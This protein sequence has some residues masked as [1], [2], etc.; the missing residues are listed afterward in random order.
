MKK[1]KIYIL[2]LI[3]F[4][5]IVNTSWA[6]T[7]TFT[8]QAGRTVNV[9]LNPQRIVSLAPSITEIVFALGEEHRLKGV[10]LFSD[11]PS[12]AKMI[13]VVGSYV[14][15]DLERIVA[16]KPDLCI[17]IKDGNSRDTVKQLD[18][19]NIPV[20]AINPK[21]LESVMD[22]VVEIGEL[23]NVLK[24]AKILA[25]DMSKRIEHIKA[26]VSKVDH[27]PRVFFQ[28]GIAP[29]VSIG[30]HTFIHELIT[31]AG[32]QN[33]TEGPIAYPRYSREQVLGLAPE[34][35]II[36]SMARGE[37]FEKVKA[38]WSR[39]KD[40]PAVKNNQ[41]Y[42]VDSNI[43]DRPTPRMVDGLEMLVKIIHPELFS[44]NS[45]S[46]LRGSQFK[47]RE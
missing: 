7:R 27:K 9:P 13:P 3:A 32:G 1:N 28:I 43:L 14:N 33:L 11:Y 6:E 16:L 31:R 39:W 22:T 38:D 18:A 40:L 37:I 17:A 29:I 20:Y 44:N 8:D 42:L 45:G 34:V 36:T 2:A 21:N 41:I 46:Q 47:V 30:T 19:L 15:L 5:L 10:T 12:E 23:L 4:C 35:F 26:L 25:N 24:E